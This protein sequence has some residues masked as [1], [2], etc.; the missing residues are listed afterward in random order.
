MDVLDQFCNLVGQ[1]VN[2]SKSRILFSPIVTRRRRRRLCNKMGIYET[3]NLG[4]YLGFPLLQQGRNNNA[5]NFVAGKIQAKLAGWKSRLLSRAG[6][7]ILIKTTAAPIADYYMQC[8]AL[9]I[10]IC[11]S[12]NK[13]MRDFLWGST[14]E[15][16]KTQHGELAYCHS[17]KRDRGVGAFPNK[18][19]ESSFVSK[20]VLALGL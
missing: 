17:A 4:R 12:I 3:S 14:E 20:V 18:A 2:K 8:H 13:K 11:N 7:L 16:K 10:K 5:F 15:K 19:P 1:K 9:P 6:R